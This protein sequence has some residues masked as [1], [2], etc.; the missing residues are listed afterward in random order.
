M[1]VSVNSSEAETQG[2][3]A[4]LRSAL[5]VLES[6]GIS[7]AASESSGTIEQLS[8]KRPLEQDAE[9]SEV[10]NEVSSAALEA[11]DAAERSIKMARTAAIALDSSRTDNADEVS[12][13][14]APATGATALT[15]DFT[16]LSTELAHPNT[17]PLETIKLVSILPSSA[18][19]IVSVGGTKS[20]QS[21]E[22]VQRILPPD[23]SVYRTLLESS[24]QKQLET[25]YDAAA[26]RQGAIG[27]RRYRVYCVTLIRSILAATSI[28]LFDS[29]DQHSSVVAVRVV[30]SLAS[31]LKES[32]PL[33][34]SV[35]VAVPLWTFAS[36]ALSQRRLQTADGLSA[37]ETPLKIDLL[38]M[39]CTSLL[40]LAGAE[41][42]STG[43]MEVA[44]DDSSESDRRVWT[45]AYESFCLV[46][47]SRLVQLA[48]LRPSARRFLTCLP[49]VP[50]TLLQCLKV[51][52]T[53]VT[54]SSGD[55]ERGVRSE[56]L[57]LLG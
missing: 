13:S 6:L 8:N 1:S 46:C 5:T 10:R 12:S 16:E 31:S 48:H 36:F 28:Y 43:A 38:I 39:L 44:T 57:S 52:V 3:I 34:V 20:R 14:G 53:T 55:K 27:A 2:A 19:S 47:L 4:K 25:F 33:P 37:V 51:L 32:S 30:K 23:S 17:S 49:Q 26:N 24:L 9:D 56:A 18:L 50:R 45:A 35:S 54:K 7:T 11:L 21:L 42:H 29:D 40:D 22:S 15:G 41:N